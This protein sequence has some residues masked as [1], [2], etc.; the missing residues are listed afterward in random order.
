MASENKKLIESYET[1]RRTVAELERIGAP[2]TPQNFN[3]WFAHF[4]GENPSLSAKIADIVSDNVTYTDE[5]SDELFDTHFSNQRVGEAVVEASGKIEAQMQQIVELIAAS[6]ASTSAYGEA[7][8]GASGQLG[9]I[10]GDP[11]KLGG[12]VNGLLSATRAMEAQNA[13]LETKLGAATHEI[14]EL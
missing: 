14:T 2:A 8:K 6:G 10:G 4:A 1:A 3:I 12:L 7:L 13:A 11:E 5:L 9:A